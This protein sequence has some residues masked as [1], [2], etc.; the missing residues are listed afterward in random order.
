MNFNQP[1]KHNR[2]NQENKENEYINN[3]CNYAS[4]GWELWCIQQ[5]IEHGGNSRKNL[6]KM[7]DPNSDVNNAI[8]DYIGDFFNAVKLSK[9]YLNDIMKTLES[10]DVTADILWNSDLFDEEDP[11][12]LEMDNRALLVSFAFT[13]FRLYL[14]SLMTQ[15][16]LNKDLILRSEVNKESKKVFEDDEDLIIKVSESLY[17]D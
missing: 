16:D 12:F 10:L 2:Q 9:L 13:Y 3:I 14:Y 15:Y 7:C 8:K 17:K 5:L 4:N 11:F 6:M 1:N